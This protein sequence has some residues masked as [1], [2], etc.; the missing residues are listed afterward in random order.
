[1][2]NWWN[3]YRRKSF[4]N[5]FLLPHLTLVEIMSIYFFRNYIQDVRDNWWFCILRS[6]LLYQLDNEHAKISIF[7]YL[8]SN[9]LQLEEARYKLPMLSRYVLYHLFSEF[10]EY[11]CHCEIMPMSNNAWVFRYTCFIVWLFLI[12]HMLDDILFKL[13]IDVLW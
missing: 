12:K 9:P 5:L 7:Y 10:C 3:P 2:G 6:L 13:I 11:A 1:M 4:Q 8:L